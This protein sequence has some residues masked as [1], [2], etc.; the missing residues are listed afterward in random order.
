M[1]DLV[2]NYKVVSLTCKKTSC[3]ASVHFSLSPTR[4]VP[5]AQVVSNPNGGHLIANY[6]VIKHSGQWLLTGSGD[7]YPMVY[8]ST[9]KKLFSK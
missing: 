5:K 7:G 1:I 3:K 8:F 4:N 6:T 9:Y 2:D